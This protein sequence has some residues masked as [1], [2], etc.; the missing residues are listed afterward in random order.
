MKA[1]LTTLL[2]IAA[3]GCASMNQSVAQEKPSTLV[4]AADAVL[5]RPLCF[6]STVVGSALFLISLPV[7]APLKKAKPLADVFV[8]RPA[9]ATFKR[10]LGDMEAMAD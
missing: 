9:K 6:T 3:I 1:R 7:A 2:C 10:P 4:K 8:V 5:V